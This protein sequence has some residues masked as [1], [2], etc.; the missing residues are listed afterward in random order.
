MFKGKIQAIG[1]IENIE[2]QPN[3]ERHAIIF[4]DFLSKKMKIDTILAINGVSLTVAKVEQ[5]IIFFDLTNEEALKLTTF[6][7]LN[8]GYKV[9]IETTP[10]FGTLTG[11][12]P[13]S[14]IITDVTNVEEIINTEGGQKMWLT[15]PIEKTEI[16]ANKKYIGIDGV[17]L[18]IEKI[19]DGHFSVN[20]DSDIL[21]QTNIGY[22]KKED[23]VN[24]EIPDCS[25]VGDW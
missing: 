19:K 14:G 24:L 5:N 16:L 10:E 21:Q 3:L 23:K 25:D 12:Y 8:I 2:K 7:Q 6:S 15:A 11:R 17:S 4:P 22:R 9:N 13:L 20:L 1:T 18:L